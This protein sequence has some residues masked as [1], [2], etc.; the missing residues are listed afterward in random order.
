MAARIELV[1]GGRMYELI[2]DASRIMVCITTPCEPQ[3]G[4]P[5]AFGAS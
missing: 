1:A 5:E 2:G 4:T 3:P